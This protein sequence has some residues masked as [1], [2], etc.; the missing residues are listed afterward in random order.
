[1]RGF[2]RNNLTSPSPPF[3]VVPLQ[4]TLLLRLHF[5]SIFHAVALLEQQQVRLSF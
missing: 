1:M 4:S 3:E 2:V 5:L